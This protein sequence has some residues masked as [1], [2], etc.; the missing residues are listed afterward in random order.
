MPLDVVAVSK[1]VEVRAFVHRE[2]RVRRTSVL[3][4]SALAPA[5]AWVVGCFGGN[6]N[7]QDAGSV[8]FDG[9]APDVT[10][11]HEEAGPSPE[12]GPARD[13]G[14][15]PE[16]AVEAEAEAEAGPPSGMIP[17]S[18]DFQQVGCGAPAAS[19]TFTVKNTGPV[20]VMYSATIANSTVFAISGSSSGT[21][22]PG[23]SASLMLTATV[24]ATATA[25]QAIAGS[26]AVTTNVPG[27]TSVTVPLSVTPLGGSLSVTPAPAAFVP[28]Q[29]STPAQAIALHVANTGNAPIDVALGA[30][31]DAE[32]TVTYTGS[33]SAV[34]LQPGASL[35]G[36]SAG[37][38]P[39]SPGDKSATSAVTVTGTMCGST[40]PL[41][42][43]GT[44]TA[45]NVTVGP[46]VLDFGTVVCGAPAPTAQA[47]TLR[48]GGTTPVTY[49]AA[50]GKGASSPFQQD[51]PTGTVA[52]NGQAV[53][54]I[55]PN[56][57]VLPASVAAN[58]YGDTLTVTTN[59]SGGAPATVMLL[60]S[61]SGALLRISMP[62]STLG[63]VPI[64]TPATLPFT[65]VN[66]GNVDA[67][68]TVSTTGSSWS[69]TLA[70]STA[71]ANGGSVPGTVVF[72]TANIMASLTTLS[73]ATTAPLCAPI[74][75]VTVAAQGEAA[76]ANVTGA[77][78]AVENT[79]GL[80][81]GTT[82][83]L[84]INNTGSTSLIV[85]NV[86]TTS[87]RLLLLAKPNGPIDPGQSGDIVVGVRDPVIGT[88][89]AG[90]YNVGVTF[91]TNE[92][93]N[94]TTTIP[95]TVTIHGANLAL[96][97]DT[98]D[99][100]G[101]SPSDCFLFAQ[102]EIANTGDLAG[103]V[104]GT[105][106]YPFGFA[107]ITFSGAFSGAT[108]IPPA[109]SVLD[110]VQAPGSTCSETDQVTFSAPTSATNPVC[111]APDVLTVNVDVPLSA[112]SCSCGL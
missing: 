70:G 30:P 56:P 75:T 101:E 85:S 9:A 94:P 13:A 43:S 52:A 55:S 87:S 68:V 3:F 24:P 91:T 82:A 71:T 96:S 69:A 78:F 97:T 40:S 17:T 105:G 2:V 111:V 15:L 102:Y 42:L 36:A 98:L 7:N 86:S 25:G 33:P 51:T 104:A 49:T 29:I 109:R 22:A 106:N 79:C 67:P 107:G 45:A 50:L 76:I 47:V 90:T 23:A 89:A 54:N 21:V 34:T 26:L 112:G 66:T 63:L 72:D 5:S 59:A 81:N 110:E 35:P 57:I 88:D 39:T 60:Q 12:V 16:A 61:A 31:T 37:F 4:L 10:Q 84:T 64:G 6:S 48:N 32:F 92:V 46:S 58:A 77:P 41:A 73:A 95:G 108:T 53:I 1:L 103:T 27:F 38:T 99:M 19:Q 93:G 11:P 80:N 100:N 18:V 62:T 74:G 65:L 83:T 20:P 14:P 8:T 44:G 28:T